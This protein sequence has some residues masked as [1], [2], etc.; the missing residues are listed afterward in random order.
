MK[1]TVKLFATL[2]K[3]GPIGL[4]IGEGFPVQLEDNSKVK[5]ILKK[6]KIPE[7]QAKIIMVNGNIV[8][9][10]SFSLKQNDQI[11]IFPPVGGGF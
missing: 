9:D 4:K 2:R 11:S 6:L 8:N 7:D 3:Y 1:V 5:T 10:I